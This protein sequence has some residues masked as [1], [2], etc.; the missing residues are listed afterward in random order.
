MEVLGLTSTRHCGPLKEPGTF[1]RFSRRSGYLCHVDALLDG[2]HFDG[3]VAARR[4][5]QRLVETGPDRAPRKTLQVLLVGPQFVQ[6]AA[7]FY[8]NQA[9]AVN[10]TGWGSFLELTD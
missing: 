10:T 5:Q 4:G 2:P 6:D 9:G 7:I 8:A 1:E 3:A